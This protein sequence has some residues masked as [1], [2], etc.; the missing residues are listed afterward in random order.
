MYA[1]IAVL[2]SLTMRYN[3]IDGPQNSYTLHKRIT[4]NIVFI[5]HRSHK[6][7]VHIVFF[8]LSREARPVSETVCVPSSGDG[9]IFE[10][11]SPSFPVSSRDHH[12]DITPRSAG[13][14]TRLRM[15]LG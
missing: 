2:F 1:N 8:I 14:E 9:K 11:L 12:D 3:L 6:S 5:F 13:P 15:L 4:Y 10:Q 7:L